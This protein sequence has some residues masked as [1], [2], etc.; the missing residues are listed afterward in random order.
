MWT[1]T[2]MPRI[3]SGATKGALPLLNTMATS[4]CWNKACPA[5]RPV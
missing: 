1:A 5:D 2:G 4:R 3:F